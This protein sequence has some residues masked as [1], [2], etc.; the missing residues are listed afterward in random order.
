MLGE[1]VAQIAQALGVPGEIE[2]MGEGVG[3]CRAERNRRKVE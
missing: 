1:P 3:R 2:G